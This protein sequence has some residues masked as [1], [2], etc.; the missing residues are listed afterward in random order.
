VS[1][2][3]FSRHDDFIQKDRVSKRANVGWIGPCAC[4]RL[5]SKVANRTLIVM[6]GCVARGQ[7][8]SASDEGSEMKRFVGKEVYLALSCSRVFGGLFGEGHNQSRMRLASG[9]GYD[10]TMQAAN[11]LTERL[12]ANNKY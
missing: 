10:L 2:P 3:D 6:S 8:A 4:L 7:S 12:A 1:A 11:L 5:A 9:R